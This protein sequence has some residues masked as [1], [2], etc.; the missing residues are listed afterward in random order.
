MFFDQLLEFGAIDQRDPVS[1]RELLARAAEPGRGYQ[2]ARRGVVIGHDAA[3]GMHRFQADDP[4]PALGL[5]QADSAKEKVL[6]GGDGR[7]SGGS[8]PSAPGR[9]VSSARPSTYCSYAKHN[10]DG[11]GSLVTGPREGGRRGIYCG[12]F[13]L[14]VKESVQIAL[15]PG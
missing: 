14:S 9:A 7:A 4:C 13:M 15:H 2:H 11:K 3:Q 10:Q 1:V 6:A 5:D 12:P 8:G